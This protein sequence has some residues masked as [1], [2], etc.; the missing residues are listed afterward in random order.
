MRCEPPDLYCGKAFKSICKKHR[1]FDES[2]KLS[3]RLVVAYFDDPQNV[4]R[5][6]QLVHLHTCEEY[7]FWKLKVMVKGLKPGQWPRLWFGVSQ[8]G[9]R[10]LIPLILDMHQSGY[11]DNQHENDAHNLLRKH[12][13]ELS[14]T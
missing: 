10:I 12:I 2:Y 1:S 7:E 11:S 14:S 9:E 3:L 4:N 13:V 8:K 6:F 5:P